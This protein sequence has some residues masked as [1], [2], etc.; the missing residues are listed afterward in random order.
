MKAFLEAI[1]DGKDVPVGGTD[2][3]YSVLIAEAALESLKSG[4][5]VKVN[6]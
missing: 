1:R 2:G 3:L 4:K 6:Y 5:S